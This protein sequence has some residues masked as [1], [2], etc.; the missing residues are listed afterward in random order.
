MKSPVPSNEAARLAAFQQYH[1]SEIKPQPWCEDLTQL[2]AH[3]CATPIAC[4]CFV[5]AD[6]LRYQSQ[7]GKCAFETSREGSFCSWA[8]LDSALLIVAETKEDE[9]FRQHPLVTAHPGIR[10]FAAA[11]VVT[12]DGHALGALCVFDWKPRT[13]STAQV[14][15]L[16]TLA[17][18]VMAQLAQPEYHRQQVEISHASDERAHLEKMLQLQEQHF[19]R[20]RSHQQ[21]L[22]QANTRLQQEISELQQELAGLVVSEE[23]YALAVNCTNDGVWDWDLKTNQV[24]YSPRWKGDA[25]L[26][27]A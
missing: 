17:D 26:R 24:Y 20:A 19:N 22:T 12:A 9:R 23:R 15:G 21:K 6:H 5:D 11:P 1:L 10:F 18:A 3:L 2:A 25:R 14:G 27:R 4:L 13:L 7:I 8:I 16:R